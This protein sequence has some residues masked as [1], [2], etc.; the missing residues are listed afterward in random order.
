[1]LLSSGEQGKNAFAIKNELL[2]GLMLFLFTINHQESVYL[3]VLL[4][5]S[6][7]ATSTNDI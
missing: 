3:H 7:Y 2:F 6:S 4:Q 1:M 5:F